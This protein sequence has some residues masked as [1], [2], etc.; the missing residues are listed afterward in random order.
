MM[1][2]LGTRLGREA[3]CTTAASGR[4]QQQFFTSQ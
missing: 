2:V 1:P 3:D 4:Y